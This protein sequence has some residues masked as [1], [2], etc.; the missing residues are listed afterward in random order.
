MNP[1]KDYDY[2]GVTSIQEILNNPY[3]EAT[4]S[5]RLGH[6]RE[7]ESISGQGLTTYWRFN[8]YASVGGDEYDIPDGGP[9]G[10]DQ[11]VKLNGVDINLQ[12][13]SVE[14]ATYNL[15]SDG[16]SLELKFNIDDRLDVQLNA[17]KR[18]LRDAQDSI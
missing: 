7:I 2:D 15:A 12:V 6:L 18:S 17:T 8:E 13:A 3:V 10:F 1:T 16:G 9:E 4:A 5:G 11:P 14:E